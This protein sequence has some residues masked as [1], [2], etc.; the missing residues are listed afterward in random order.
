VSSHLSAINT[1]CL[2]ISIPL[3][4]FR[5]L[6]S[7]IKWSGHDGNSCT[8]TACLRKPL[9]TSEVVLQSTISKTSVLYLCRIALVLRNGETK[10]A[11]GLGRI[12]ATMRKLTEL[13]VRY[14]C[15]TT[16]LCGRSRQ[17][18]SDPVTP[19]YRL[20]GPSGCNVRSVKTMMGLSK[21]RFI[22]SKSCDRNQRRQVASRVYIPPARTHLQICQAFFRHPIQ[23]YSFLF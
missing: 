17:S 22:S 20:S 16:R 2:C 7:S 19:T 12:S 11:L 15:K 10:L 1:F 23:Y 8:L 18:P 14:E 3:R 13:A 6:H 4:T 21:G 9:V 5:F